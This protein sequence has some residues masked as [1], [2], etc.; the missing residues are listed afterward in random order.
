M[1]DPGTGGLTLSPSESR[2]VTDEKV[3]RYLVDLEVVKAPRLQ[4]CVSVVCVAPDAAATEASRFSK[5][6]VLAA[7]LR[8]T[9]ATDVVTELADGSL[10]VLLIDAETTALPAIIGRLREELLAVTSVAVPPVT[11][12]AGAACY[13]TTA[14]SPAEVVRLAVDLLARARGAGG[15]RSYVAP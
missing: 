10:A 14:T 7:I 12:S 15:D 11:W 1:L 3:F 9:R 4:Y 6:H 5:P 2:R 13:P 8:C